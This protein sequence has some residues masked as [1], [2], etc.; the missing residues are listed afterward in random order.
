MMMMMMKNDIFYSFSVPTLFLKLPWYFQTLR[1]CEFFLKLRTRTGKVW[2]LTRASQTSCGCGL[3]VDF[4][5]WYVYVEELIN[6]IAQYTISID[7]GSS[8]LNW[9]WVVEGES[10]KCLD[11]CWTIGG[12]GTLI[13]RHFLARYMSIDRN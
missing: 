8:T 2:N 6:F 12:A 13:L 11:L 4:K 7:C 10:L 1:V 9:P 3:K 5:H